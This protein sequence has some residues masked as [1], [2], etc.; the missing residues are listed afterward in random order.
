M[1]ASGNHQIGVRIG[2]KWFVIGQMTLESA[3]APGKSGGMSRPIPLRGAVQKWADHEVTV[4]RRS[5]T[6]A[7][8]AATTVLRIAKD[9]GWVVVGDMTRADA[10][11]WL[12]RF[13]REG[14]PGAAKTAHNHRS[15]LRAFAAYLSETNDAPADLFDGLRLPAAR[16]AHGASAFTWGEMGSLIARARQSERTDKRAGKFGPMRSTFYSVLALTGLR[17]RE[18]RLQRW[19]D[20]NLERRT[21]IVSAD[22]S[23]RRDPIRYN[24]ECAVI[25]RAWRKWS[26]GERL[27][28]RVPSHHT[29][30]SDMA[31]CGIPSAE[32]GK[33][34]QWH[35]FRKG[36]C[37]ELAVQGVDLEQ[38][39]RV[40]RHKDTRITADLYTD[41]EIVDI[42]VSAENTVVCL[43]TL[44]KNRGKVP[45]RLTEVSPMDETKGVKAMASTPSQP[46]T[47]KNRTVP[48]A[49]G[50]DNRPS[51]RCGSSR[52]LCEQAR[53]QQNGA[54]GNRPY[55]GMS[56]ML[57]EVIDAQ[58]RAFQALRAAL[59]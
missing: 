10:V 21:L 42:S 50:L 14:G 20:V 23:R 28:P 55:G 32:D 12:R 54:G 36:L 24:A 9:C 51:G 59:N 6:E 44:R 35:R 46:V 5:E 30:V 29:L 18:A 22:K 34:G 40:M 31:A 33:R 15:R 53:T 4:N 49:N 26:R 17:F 52:S 3:G 13:I 27:F 2:D 16:T 48:G 25:L 41:A 8:K 39:R 1:G 19:E 38:R 43:P 37:S 11:K 45:H 56:A 7:R 57:A 47:E 58:I